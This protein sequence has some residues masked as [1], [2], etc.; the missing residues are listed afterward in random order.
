MHFHC[1][2]FLVW[3]GGWQL[4]VSLCVLRVDNVDDAED[5][6]NMKL[7]IDADALIESHGGVSEFSRY[8]TDK[9][10]AVSRQCVSKWGREKMI[11]MRAWLRIYAIELA[12]GIRLDLRAFI[13]EGK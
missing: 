5:K 3:N 9:G 8:L 6:H 4:F 11:P 13:K 2:Y 12:C 7:H 1:A 10:Y